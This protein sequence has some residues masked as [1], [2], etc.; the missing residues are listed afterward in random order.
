MEPKLQLCRNSCFLPPLF[1][2]RPRFRKIQAKGNRH[3][4]FLRCD[5]KTHGNPAVILLPHLPAVLARYS[6]GMLTFFGETRIVYDPCD[7]RRLPQYRSQHRIEGAVEQ[8][9]IIPGGVG[10]QM[11]VALG[12]KG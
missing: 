2:V 8:C 5:G 7:N 4:R 11:M 3:T 12:L 10:Y 1:I 9:F 6:H